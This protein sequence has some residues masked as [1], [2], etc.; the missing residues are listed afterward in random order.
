MEK[1]IDKLFELCANT[2]QTFGFFDKEATDRECEFFDYLLNNLP[3]E[4]KN[5]FSKYIELRGIRTA[6]ELQAAYESGFKTA[7]QLFVEA[8]HT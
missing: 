6:N 7:V 5:I 2:S 8:L 1:I 4:H 3:P